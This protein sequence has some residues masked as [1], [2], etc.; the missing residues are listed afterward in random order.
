MQQ[1]TGERDI[2]LGCGAEMVRR[3]R[4]VN[5]GL[6]VREERQVRCVDC[7]FREYFKSKTLVQRCP[8]RVPVERPTVAGKAPARMQQVLEAAFA[9][10]GEAS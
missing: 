8:Y 4:R 2:C 1:A 10:E 5:M 3:M 6:I 9:E 7:G